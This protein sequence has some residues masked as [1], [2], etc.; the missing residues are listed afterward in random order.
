MEKIQILNE[1]PSWD[2]T[3]QSRRWPHLGTARSEVLRE[4]AEMQLVK[5]SLVFEVCKESLEP[6]LRNSASLLRSYAS[7]LQL[8]LQSSRSRLG[9]ELAEEVAQSGP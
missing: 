5:R 8:T 6:A 7:L 2:R 3:V 9:D 1:G 4:L